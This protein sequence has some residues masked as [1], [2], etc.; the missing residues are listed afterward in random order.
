V[1]NWSSA[2][3]GGSKHW[4]ISKLTLKSP[5]SCAQDTAAV[6]ADGYRL[7]GNFL[8]TPRT[9]DNCQ[10]GTVACGGLGTCGSNVFVLGNELAFAQ[11]VNAATGSKQCHGF[12]ISGNRTT[13]GLESGRDIGWNY[14]HD[15]A[16]N[17]GINIYNESYNGASAPRSQIERHLV[18]DNWVENQRGIGLLMGADITG[19]NWVFNN[20]FVNTGLGPVFVDGG[21]FFPFQLQPGSAVPVRPTQLHV[22]NNLIHGASFPSGPDYAVALVSWQQAAQSTLDFRNNVVVG[23]QSGVPYV[24]QYSDAFMSSFN[25]WVGSGAPPSGATASLNTAP[26]FVGATAFDFHLAAGSAGKGAGADLSALGVGAL[27]FDGVPRTGSW[28]MGPFQ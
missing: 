16:N 2:E 21:G 12:Y 7:V 1:N 26:T 27:D 4:V 18:H 23:T 5:P 11:T 8:S 28:S 20:V 6:V 3:N 10:T 17:R 25:L 19:D 22:F 14:L 9:A 15:N 24:N 13:A